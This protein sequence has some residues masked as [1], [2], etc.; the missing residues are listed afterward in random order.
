MKKK[1]VRE[2]LAL[3]LIAA[4]TTSTVFPAMAS[5]ASV[6]A[7]QVISWKE[8]RID[9]FRK[10][11]SSTA[12]RL[13]EKEKQTP[14]NAISQDEIF[15]LDEMPEIGTDA[16]TKWFFANT[17]HEELWEFVLDL[18]DRRESEEYEQFMAWV[19]E[20]EDSFSEAFYKYTGEIFPFSMATG[21]LWEEWIGAKMNW[22]GSGSES[23]PY[24][25]TSLSELMGLSEAV[26]QGEDYSGKYFELQ[27]DIDLGR[28]ILNNGC[29]NPIGWYKNA[30]D[31]EGKPKT[32][33]AG[34][35]DGAGNTISGLKFTK[36]D[37]DYSY[38][39]LFGWIKDA[40][41]KNLN[42]EADEVSGDDNIGL[43]AGCVEGNSTIH[44]VT[45]NGALY[46]EG[47]AGSI[48]GEITGGTKHTIIENCVADTVSINSEGTDSYVGGIAGNVQKAEIIDCVVSTLDG[49]SNRIQGKGCVG[50][51]IGRQNITNVYNS[52]VTG[53][54]GGNKTK[55]VGGI[56]GLYESG[57]IVVVQ[58]DGEIGHTYNGTASHEGSIIG[59]REARN[60]FR[61]GTGKRDNLSYLY[62][63]DAAQTKTIVGSG[64][65]DD[66][67][68]TMDA[69]VGYYTDYQR[70]Y[71][72]VA[73]TNEQGCGERFF[74]E[75]LE[76]GIQY[77]IT[78]KLGKD[79]T[80]DQANGVGFR[81][82]HFAPGNQGEP[83]TGYLVAIS[84]IDAK[85]ANGTFDNDVATL[86]AISATNNSYYR[87]I[88]KDHPSAVAPGCTITVATAAKNTNENRYQMVYDENEAGKV[89]PP[90]Y[91]D[92]SGEKQNMTYVNGGSYSFVMPES[93][94]ELNVEYMKVTTQ[95]SMTPK[96]TEISVTHTRTGDRK[97]PK[98]TTEVR[99]HDGTL[100][101]R[102]INGTQDVSVQVLPVPI[103]AEHNSTGSTADRTVK[104]S[105]DDTDLL[106]FEDGWKEDY[107]TKDAR[108]IPNMESQFIQRIIEREVK[109]Q[110]DSGY[111]QPIS[112]TI[113]T[114]SAV[115]TASTN[116]ATSVDNKVVT[117]ACKV[118][119]TFQIIDQTTLR[120]ENLVLN[121]TDISFDIIRKL[122]GDRKD[123]VEEYIV[124][125]PIGLDAS[126]NP[127][128]S[129]YKNVTWA[130]RESGKVIRL[131]PSGANQQNCSVSVVFDAD[132]TNNPAWIQNIINADDSAKAAAHGYLKLNGNGSVKELITATSEDQTNGVIT[133]TCN[134]TIN[135]KTDD[136]TVIHPEG[137]VLTETSLDYDL[138]YQYAGDIHSEVTEKTGLGE[139]DILSAIVLPNIE[140]NDGHMPYNRNVIWISSDPDALSVTDGKLIVNDQAQWI[141][142][143][144]KEVPYKAEKVV[145]ITAVTE[146]GEKQATC[147][148]TLRF[149]ASVLE[150]DRE[151]ETFDI[152][153]TKTGNKQNPT[154]SWTGTDPKKF[155]A[156]IYNEDKGVTAVWK[157]SNHTL[158]TV[159]KDGDVSPVVINADGTIITDW[160]LEAMKNYP[161]KAE[162]SADI[163][164]IAS[165][166][167]MSDTIPVKLTFTLVDRTYSSGGGSSSGG[168]GG[169]SSGGG[170]S[171][172]GGTVTS[173]TQGAFGS[174]PSGSVTGIWTQT[175]DGKWMFT[176]NERTYADEWAYIYNPYAKDGQ[177]TADWFRFDKTGFMVT[178]WH[179]DVDG[180]SYYLHSVSDNTLGHMYTGWRWIDDNGDGLAECYYFNP[181]V[182][183]PKGSMLKGTA[184]P[185][186]YIVNEKGQWV[187]NGIVQT[188]AIG[189]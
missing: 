27:T 183:A 115:V 177:N 168:G 55:A 86:T 130:D 184:T 110:V 30:S 153:L 9:G 29:W 189:K 50:G 33:F 13:P 146:D 98:I 175:L 185:D 167:S 46:A 101:A 122:T 81:I 136:Q 138:H 150:A 67:T 54:F 171:S 125:G 75:E 159:S 113:Y 66:N 23:D 28:L 26:T 132:T 87:Q 95:L 40:T 5:I 100:I 39:G 21:D 135:F 152:V 108:V 94:T 120:V 169:S 181:T 60:G 145:T 107:T 77:I 118:D 165:D 166:D 92:E 41:I 12:D 139:R 43:L 16:F 52:Y 10:A 137:I 35:F 134:V 133:A 69:H 163:Q 117:G 126:L 38:L 180:H 174:R 7:G 128:Q 104:W 155:T 49:G 121:Q 57:D 111:Q 4:M 6:D 32:A 79:L 89:K 71:T 170:G 1:F 178:G 34:T 8:T 97:N 131:T 109:K 58:M 11:T 47:D 172:T 19:L 56:T 31:L 25:I 45:V 157:S 114:D 48:A 141:K 22:S 127:S 103:H 70:K 161:Y 164:V 53:T 78:Q 90:T 96:E 64:I 106:H 162:N 84:R 18:L 76:D 143:A 15:D 142:K 65:S 42:L 119:I 74:Y 105:I 20:N 24:K 82:D 51:M 85:N 187:M 83:V 17:E 72:Q 156:S 91:T 63:G 73:G 124:T 2:S 102:Y 151:G 44:N 176:E 129:F 173:G 68:W 154:L 182:G 3:L 112:N 37:H 158:L 186:G 88:D 80:I 93:D 140:V 123:P 179:Y 188:Q 59:T 144:L 149:M 14:S 99:N 147:D 148:V 62:V 36:I 160:I 116:P 61:Y